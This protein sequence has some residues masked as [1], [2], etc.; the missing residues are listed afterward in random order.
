M[1]ILDWAPYKFSVA[2]VESLGILGGITYRKT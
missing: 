2:Q 1:V